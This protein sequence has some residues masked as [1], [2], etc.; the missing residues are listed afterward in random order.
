MMHTR[1]QCLA[2]TGVSLAMKLN[3]LLLHEMTTPWLFDI[4]IAAF[5][6]IM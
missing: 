5:S 6:D 1:R 3:P 4:L 2:G